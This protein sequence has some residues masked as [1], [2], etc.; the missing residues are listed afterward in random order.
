MKA[1]TLSLLATLAGSAGTLW[2][3]PANDMLPSGRTFTELRE[4]ERNPFG[5]QISV[6]PQIVEESESEEARLR[7]IVSSVKISGVSESAGKKRVLLG[8]MILQVGDI[9]PPLIRG[10]QESLRVSSIDSERILLAF[11]ERDPG[12]ES[13]QITIPLEMT[14]RVNQFLYGEAV[15]KLMNPDASADG[16]EIPVAGVDEFFKGSSDASLQNVTNRKFQM[17]GEVKDD[18]TEIQAP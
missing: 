8:S 17:M 16:S 10:Q 15:E 3:D 11:V 6:Q 12:I 5:Q 14:P 1:L 7:R 9:L 18:K 13:R 4:G 2:A